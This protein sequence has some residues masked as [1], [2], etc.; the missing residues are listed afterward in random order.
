MRQQTAKWILKDRYRINAL[1]AAR[2]LELSDWYLAAGFVRNLVW[3]KL[4]DYEIRTPL[5]DIDLVYFDKNNLDEAIER[6][7][8]SKLKEICNLPWSVKNQARMHLPNNDSPYRST[9]DAMRYWPEIETAI[10]VKLNYDGEIELVAPFGLNALFSK[11]ITINSNK[12]KPAIFKQRI[13]KKSW[14]SCWPNLTIINKNQIN[15][16][17][18]K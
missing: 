18:L 4:H 6:K 17:I 5:N 10:G 14:L 3:D 16:D 12:P 9:E 1:Q 13:E 11:T 2:D 8:I 7:S 15:K